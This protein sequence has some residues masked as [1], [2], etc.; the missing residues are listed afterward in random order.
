MRALVVYESMF[1]NTERL[2]QAI[3]EELA[4]A[5]TVEVINVD[6]APRTLD[7]I[8][9]LVVG[10]PTHVFGLSRPQTRVDAASRWDTDPVTRGTGMRDWLELISPASSRTVAV[11][12]ATRMRK[13]RWLTGSAA[14][15]A[16]RLLRRAGFGVDAPEDFFVS[17]MLGPL[18]DGEIDR[19]HAWARE[20][21]EVVPAAG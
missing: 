15:S 16:T 3:G 6:D 5:G 18:F 13:P 4:A 9:L 12:F 8:D 11:A 21:A 2:A 17:G 10:A 14:R 1:G 19:A 7:D 20:L